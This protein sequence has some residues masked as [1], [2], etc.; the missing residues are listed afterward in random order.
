LKGAAKRA[1]MQPRLALIRIQH[2]IDRRN[3]QVGPLRRLWIAPSG[4][5]FPRTLA[6]TAALELLEAD[7]A[8]RNAAIHLR[9]EGR[10]ICL[11]LGDALITLAGGLLHRIT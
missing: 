2:A 8:P 9:L 11:Q 3:C 7:A 1:V 5:R 6:L 10:Q 4:T